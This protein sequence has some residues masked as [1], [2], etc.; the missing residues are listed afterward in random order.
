MVRIHEHGSKQS[1]RQKLLRTFSW[2]VLVLSWNLA[3][4]PLDLLQNIKTHF[5]IILYYSVK[6]DCNL[7]G[8]QYSLSITNAWALKTTE[9]KRENGCVK[10]VSNSV[11]SSHK[12]SITRMSSFLSTK[13]QQPYSHPMNT[14][15][16]ETNYHFF[17]GQQHYCPAVKRN[18]WIY[19]ISAPKNLS[20]LNADRHY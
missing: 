18:L 19:P 7:T 20:Y 14:G 6:K 10:Q 8:D 13:T 12:T 16:I 5:N 11:S 4:P 17:N 9:V 15:W 2:R 1:F 3:F